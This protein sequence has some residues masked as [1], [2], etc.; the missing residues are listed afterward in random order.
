MRDWTSVGWI[1]VCAVVAVGATPGTASADEESVRTTG[2]DVIRG[3]VIDYREGQD[4]VV[5]LENG[6]RVRVPAARVARVDLV[7][8]QRD[9][10]PSLTM[11][12]ILMPAGVGLGLLGLGLGLMATSC[13]LDWEG[14]CETDDEGL[15]L[16]VGL[17]VMG[18]LVFLVG[19]FVVLP[20]QVRKRQAWNEGR[21][22]RITPSL[23]RRGGRLSL[24]VTF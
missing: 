12:L 4:A 13:F 16:G 2:G 5:E 1:V 3:D 20:I 22:V 8:E 14:D 21:N 18:G 23:G 17:G 24:G 10:R 11:P 19:A 7:V 9:P 6:E 15:A